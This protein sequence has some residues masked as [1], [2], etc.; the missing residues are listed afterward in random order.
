M[1]AELPDQL[2]HFEVG[3]TPLCFTLGAGQLSL[4]MQLLLNESQQINPLF[5]R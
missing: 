4:F 5:G 3:P 2:E 1:E